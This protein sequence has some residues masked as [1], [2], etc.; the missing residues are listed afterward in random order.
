MKAFIVFGVVIHLLF[1]YSIFYIYFQTIIVE[2]LTPQKDL[3]NPPAKRL[4]PPIQL[5][6]LPK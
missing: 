1:L 3:K 4:V 6:L 2:D 5:M